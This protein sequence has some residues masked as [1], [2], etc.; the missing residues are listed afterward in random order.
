MQVR[1]HRWNQQTGWDASLTEALTD[2]QLILL[3]GSPDALL[4]GDRSSLQAA[5]PNAQ[6]L[7]CS[8]AGEIFQ[9][10]VMDEGLVA[11][12]VQFDHTQIKGFDIHLSADEDSYAIGERL[13][14]KIDPQNLIHVFVLSDGLQVNGSELVRGLAQHLPAGVTITGGLAGDGDRFGQTSVVWNGLP[15]SSK[16]VTLG[17]YGDRLKVGFGSYGGWQ[18]FGPERVITKSVGNVLYELDGEPA[19]ALYKKYLG[20]HAAD[21]PA[22]GLLFPLSLQ[23]ESSDRYLVRTILAVN[24]AE[25]SLTFAGDVPTGAVAQLMQASFDCLVDGAM[26]AA[27]VSLQTLAGQTPDLAILISCVGRKLLL[28]Q[29]IEEEV[30]GVQEV[31][32]DRTV[33][34]G[35]YSYGEISPF[36]AGVS[37]ELHNQTMTITTLLEI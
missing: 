33:L 18:P 25:Q 36:A 28:N 37:C 19:L 1:Q 27:T 32:G 12:A 35:F 2:A 20:S 9:T 34:T 10:Q 15:E 14:Q 24:E 22:S 3:F 4:K 23:L 17:L 11:T 30:E 31:L 8:T 29:R 6:V 21:L 7:G 13:G 5:Y 16:I 26:Q